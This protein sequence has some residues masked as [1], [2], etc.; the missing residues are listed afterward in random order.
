MP[1]LIG[2]AGKAGAGKDTAA[3]Y[4]CTM[5]GF[6]KISFADPLKKAAEHMFGLKRDYFHDRSLKEQVVKIWG[7][8]PRRML[9][10]LGNDATKPFF[11][12]DLWLK[13]F[14]I[15]YQPIAM[16]EDVVVPDVRF[17]LEAEAIRAQGGT[18]L[19]LTR[20]TGGLSGDAAAHASE[21]GVMKVSGDMLISNES[22]V[23]DL[24]AGL[25]MLLGEP[26]ER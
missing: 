5:W 2:I 1:R 14:L 8:S 7:M 16:S 25:D 4:L 24:Y 12:E 23:E 22:S 20:N 6:T 3:D 17:N 26:I 9:Q 10:I 18:I 19:H 11:G 21:S 15:T 13:R